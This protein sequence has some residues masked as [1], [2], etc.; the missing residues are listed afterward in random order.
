MNGGRQVK[1]SG[2]LAA[3][4]LLFRRMSGREE[5]GRLFEYDLE[6]LSLDEKIKL[7]DV[8]GK[9]MTV[10]LLLQDDTVRYFNGYV[11][12]FSYHGRS[13][14]YAVYHATLRPWLWFLTR[15]A[16][17]RIFQNETVPDIIKKVFR[18]Q[19]FSDLSESFQ[20]GYGP[21]PYCVQYRETDFNFVSRLIEQEGIYYFFAHEDGKHILKLADSY[22]AHAPAPGYAQ[23]KYYPPTENVV[24]EEDHVDSWLVTQEI[25]TG[26]Y[27][28]QDFD[29]EK[30][31]ADLAAKSTVKRS[32][33]QASHEIYD[34]PGEYLTTAEGEAYAK[35]R[36]EELQSQYEQVKGTGNAR[37]LGVGMLF[38]LAN[39][40]RPDQNREYL[41][42]S[43][44]YHLATAEHESG[45]GE[46]G[47]T[48]FSVQFTA[49]DSKQPYR[50]ERL[51]PKPIVQGP[52]T[53]IVVGKAGEEIWT[54][55][56]GRVKVQFHWDREG[57][58]KKDEGISCWVRVAQAWAGASWGSIHVPRIGQ[59]V[60]VEFLEG[61]PDWPIITGRVYNADQMPPY[62]LPGNATQSGIKSRST[63]GGGPDNFNEFRF[64][65][66]KGQEQVFLHA[67]R[68]QDIEVEKDETHWVGHDRTKKVD[69]DESTTIGANRTESVGKDES[70][71]I[72]ENRTENVGK[73]ESITIGESR[74][75]SVGKNESITIGE[76]RTESVGKNESITIGESR[77][78]S[79]GKDESISIAGQRT[80][81]VAKKETVNIGEDRFVTVGKNDSL[82]V[83]KKG[84]IVVGD[85]LTI[86]VGDASIVMKKNG[87]ISIK[88]KDITLEGSGKINVK[89]SGDIIMKGSKIK[90]N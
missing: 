73:N 52:Q 23:V 48:D 53:A 24:R 56:Y 28:L 35:V 42:V 66:K 50:A 10:S 15:A 18:D 8:L 82:Q 12:Q 43:A 75:E 86:K 67:E 87:E 68:N 49:I 6:L 84:M 37:G 20:G 41:I 19:G 39:H 70:I 54:D 69:N 44:S 26:T 22:G 45:N 9:P 76:N 11:S 30:P 90:Q 2:P 7:Q 58:K 80:E 79:V 1:V 65:D 88:G 47:G 14:G 89:A 55:D 27:A 29:F 74:T 78:E 83:G 5:L 72:G 38:K 57:R 17:C 21:W 62:T 77:T 4:V 13:G 33:P 36:I 85:E 34:Y 59:E 40:P 16:D 31:R 60:I 64:E 81:D 61:D 63:K 51:T 25:Q 32:H 71:T 3:D 46:A